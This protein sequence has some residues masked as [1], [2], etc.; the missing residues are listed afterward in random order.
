MTTAAKAAFGTTLTWNSQTVAELTNIGGVEI[1][2][3]MLDVTSHQ[4]TSGFKEFIAGLAEAGDVA[5]EG[6]FKYDDTNGQIAMAADVASKT[7]RTAVITFPSSI[8]TWT[9]TAYIS[10]LKV[11]DT[12]ADGKIPFTATMKI[13]GVPVLATSASNN[14]TDL[15]FTTATLYPTFAA[16][17]YNYVGTSTEASV[18]VTATFAAGTCAVY[19]NGVFSQYLTSTVASSAISLGSS[20]T[21][22]TITLVVQETGKTAKTYTFEIA[23]TA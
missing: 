16:A 5:V 11:G 13:T 17:T 22:T 9:F 15:T 1:S 4:A 18:T 2:V 7:S 8:A 10:K 3:D 19:V 23:K 21:M 6:N 12:A 20:G 14:I